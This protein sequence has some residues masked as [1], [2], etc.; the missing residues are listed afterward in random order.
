[1]SRT[2]VQR[3][4]SIDMSILRMVQ[5]MGVIDGLG[6]LMTQIE[7]SNDRHVRARINRLQAAGLIDVQIPTMHGRGH[8]IVIRRRDGQ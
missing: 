7:C 2:C 4:S 6:N 1:M 8:K 5:D 3:L